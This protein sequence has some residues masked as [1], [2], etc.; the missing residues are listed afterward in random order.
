MYKS[1]LL[2]AVFVTLFFGLGILTATL[3]VIYLVIVEASALGLEVIA[4]SV[5]ALATA[6]TPYLWVVKEESSPQMGC[7]N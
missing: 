2:M 5:L 3:A 6:F 1:I 7:Q 4:F